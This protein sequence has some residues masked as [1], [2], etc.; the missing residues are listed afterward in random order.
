MARK[1]TAQELSILKKISTSFAGQEITLSHFQPCEFISANEADGDDTIPLL[2]RMFEKDRWINCRFAKPPT[3]QSLEWHTPRIDA[4][5]PEGANIAFDLTP[6]GRRCIGT[7][8]SQSTKATDQVEKARA[9]A[10]IYTSLSKAIEAQTVNKPK[11]EPQAVLQIAKAIAGRRGQADFRQHLIKAYEGRCAITG[12]QDH[13]VLEAAHIRPHS[14]QGTFEVS[15]GLLLRADI[16]T[17][18]DLHLITVDTSAAPA[19][20][21]V[22]SQQLEHSAYTEL[23][24][25]KLYLPKDEAQKPDIK[26]LNEHRL[27]AEGSYPIPG[28]AG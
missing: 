14:N 12:C 11:N 1:L 15:N 22:I 26:S 2:R 5:N 8:Q 6:L 27:K 28:I 21:I 16:H 13:E 9:T 20:T 10:P 4:C 19:L 23:H 25:R 7:G 17:L 3:T 24:K 18:F